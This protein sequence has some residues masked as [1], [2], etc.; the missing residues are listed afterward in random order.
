[1]SYIVPRS[2]PKRCMSPKCP[3][4][5]TNTFDCRLQDKSH[6]SFEEQYQ[7]CPLIAIPTP[8]GR[9]IDAD[10]FINGETDCFYETEMDLKN[11]PTVI[12]AEK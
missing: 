5:I 3:F 9:L 1:M 11:A 7:H 4:I 2:K 12:E 8:H 10:K 6:E